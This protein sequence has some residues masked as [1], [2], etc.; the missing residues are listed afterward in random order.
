MTSDLSTPPGFSG[1]AAAFTPRDPDQ[2]AAAPTSPP[3]LQSATLMMVRDQDG[4]AR[5]LSEA[6][7]SVPTAGPIEGAIHH[8]AP[9]KLSFRSRSGLPLTASEA[10]PDTLVRMPSGEVWE[11]SILV[12]S[13][14]LVELP[15]G[16]YAL[17]GLQQQ[18]QEAPQ[19][20]PQD[21]SQQPQE[22]QPQAQ[23]EAP[24]DAATFAPDTAAALSSMAEMVGQTALIDAV[25]AYARGEDLPDRLF[26]KLGQHVGD[27][28]TAI[29]AIDAAKAAYQDQ[30][31]SVLDQSLGEGLA[32][33]ATEWA[34][35][36]G[37]SKALRDAIHA[38][39][40]QGDLSGYR[41][42]ASAFLETLPAETVLSATLPE[43]FSARRGER[44]EVIV[45]TPDV[46]EVEWVSGLRSGLLRVGRR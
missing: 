21:T 45:S 5:S 29:R 14:E 35:Q 16:G 17:P 31:W 28:E 40:T 26:D 24:L 41:K 32:E 18:H 34:H 11:A 9:G 43:G 19:A 36:P 38:Q 12:K 42:L 4:H 22:A 6:T 33:L 8:S 1:G 27:Q 44:G 7:R 13:G 37:Q 20:Q 46:G 30:A 25:D 3:G 23:P 2:G 39:V 15:N 10:K